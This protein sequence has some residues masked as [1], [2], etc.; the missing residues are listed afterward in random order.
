MAIYNSLLELIG[1][2]PIVE[3]SSFLSKV[4]CKAKILAKL[5]GFNPCGSAKDRI[6]KEIIEAMEKD[7]TLKPG[8]T[9]IEPTSGNTGIALSAISAYKGYKCIIVMP[10]SMS[11]ERQKL[12]RAYGAE[13]I[14]T[15][16]AEGM[17]GAIRK[18]EELKSK[19]SGA[20]IAGQF[21]SKMN[22]EA[23]YKTTG[24]E[25]FEATGGEVDIL[26][27]AVGTGGTLSGTGKYLKEKKNTIK[28]IAVEPE[29]SPLLS[30]GYSAPHKIQG[31]GANFIPKTLNT[32]IIDEIYTVSNEGAY[33]YARLFAK[34]EGIL[35][36]ISSGAALSAAVEISKKKENEGKTIV[37]ILPDSGE[38][39]LSTPDFI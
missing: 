30:K 28:I 7:G 27:S 19:I 29:S 23:H 14:L 6:A 2:T 16:G 15:P 25:I 20:V 33:E 32:E 38:R 10:D 5:E 34:S 17:A 13:V 22:P 3:I 26:V 39:Y 9:I 36:G 8:G 35:V 31:I 4:G 24:P 12:M 21:E 37:V 11:E 1:N 18:A